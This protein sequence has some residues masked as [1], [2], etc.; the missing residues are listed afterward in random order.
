MKRLTSIASIAWALM[1]AVAAPALASQ[2]PP[3]VGVNLVNEPYKQTA[4]EQEATFRALQAAGVHVIR[5]GIPDND[6]GLAFA[7]R[8]YPTGSRSNDWSASILTP[9]RNGR[10]CPTPTR[11]KAQEHLTTTDNG[12][13]AARGRLMRAVLALAD[14]GVAPP[15]TDP[16]THRVRSASVVLSASEPFQEAARY[17]LLARPG[18]APVSV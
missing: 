8:A 1:T 9:E 5:A 11:A 3:V 10:D 18:V 16:M 2:P 15:G 12:I 6:Q 17:A 4:L 14:K 7:Q 13:V